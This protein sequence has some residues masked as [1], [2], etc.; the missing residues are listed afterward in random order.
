MLPTETSLKNGSL[1]VVG[2]GIKFISHLTS[3]AKAYIQQSDIVLYLLNEPLLKEWISQQ[4]KNTESLDMLY[5]SHHERSKSY[6]AISEYILKNVR[7]NKHVCVVIYGH[8]CVYSSPGLNA[9]KQAKA[10]GF[11][12]K[13][14]PG[15]SAE[16]CLFADLMINPGDIGYQSFEATDFLLHKKKFNP[17]CHLILWQ[18]D[19]IE[20]RTNYT[21]EN[22]NGIKLLAT[23]LCKFYNP[24]HDIVVYEAA[25]YPGLE[26]KVFNLPINKLPLT[27]LSSISTLYI[28]PIISA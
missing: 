28:P 25:Q 9:A 11:Y 8:P 10:E 1:V 21:H 20:S 12:S 27:L 3:E 23:Y 24:M 14:L 22:E 16:A 19:A 7:D 4:N 6:K 5:F 17:S 26:A 15:I 2:S 13:I 18:A